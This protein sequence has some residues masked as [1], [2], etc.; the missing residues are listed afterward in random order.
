MKIIFVNKLLANKQGSDE[1]V[2]PEIAKEFQQRL[3]NI[4][5]KDMKI[6][7]GL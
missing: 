6:I 2:D 1:K 5:I 3:N 4:L 7:N